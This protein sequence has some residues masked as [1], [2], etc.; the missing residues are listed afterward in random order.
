MSDIRPVIRS[1]CT[2]VSV[3]G[4][5]VLIKYYLLLK[6]GFPVPFGVSSIEWLTVRESFREAVL[7]DNDQGAEFYLDVLL[8]I[9]N[10]G[11]IGNPDLTAPSKGELL[12]RYPGYYGED[13]V[14]KIRQ[15]VE[16][17]LQ[18][19]YTGKELTESSGA[20][21]GEVYDLEHNYYEE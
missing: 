5:G 12:K 2:K 20:L 8:V 19:T 1:F 14:E 17:R 9:D 7:A 3:S 13:N 21:V 6:G 15:L 10:R 4:D 11:A 18:G 16:E